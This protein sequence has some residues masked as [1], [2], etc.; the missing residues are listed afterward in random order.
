MSHDVRTGCLT[1]IAGSVVHAEVDREVMLGEVMRIGDEG[2]LGEVVALENHS[3]TLQVYEETAGLTSGAPVFATGQL[4]E[5]ELGPG[6][7]G[8]VFDGIQRPLHRIAEATG[9]FLGRG[10]R[11]S[12]LDRNRL[13]EFVPT[14]EVGDVVRGGSVLGTVRETPAL[15]HR[16]LVPPHMS[17]RIAEVVGPGPHRIVDVVAR[18]AADDGSRPALNLFHT[19]RVRRPRPFAERLAPTMPMLTGQRVLDTFFPLPLGGACG[20]PGGFGTGKTIMQQ[21]LC[22]WAHADVI[23]YVGCGERGNEMTEMLTKLPNLVDPRTARP[24]AERTVLIANTSN[25]PVPAREGSIYTGATIAEYYRD[26]GYHVALLADSTSRWAEALRDISGRLGE[27]PAEEGYPPYL[28][29]R[30]AGYYER[31]ARVR[32]LAGG[33]GSVTLISAISPP[34]GD[35][36]EAVTRHTQRFTQCFWTL[37]KSL[38]EARMYPAV[39]LRDSYSRLPDELVAWWRATASPEWPALRTAALTMLEEAARAD[40]TARLVGADTLPERQQ[41]LLAMARL[42]EDGF[43]RQNAYDPVDASCSPVRQFRLLRLLL[44]VHA[45]GLQ[46]VDRGAT[47]KALAA[48]PVLSSIARARSEIG[49]DNLAA[50]DALESEVDTACA[51]VAPGEAAV[52]P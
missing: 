51:S 1:A 42:F 21:Q 39:S 24:L 34:G 18:L 43:L 33:E 19:W 44:R 49:D 45:R 50:L 6:L 10:Q 52:A 41:W 26:M 48:M 29:S 40:A 20:M 46:A 30:L 31:A 14:V 17:G 23:V 27:V 12:A 5:V 36:T 22:K 32:T 25:M 38:A 37:D 9:N 2:L 15:E 7:L 35:L 47:A 4:F 13:W 16:V 3:A 11:A 28:A 8:S